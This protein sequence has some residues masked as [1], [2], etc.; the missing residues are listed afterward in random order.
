M[1]IVVVQHNQPTS[2]DSMIQS[3]NTFWTRDS[4]ITKSEILGILTTGREA[5]NSERRG[6]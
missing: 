4:V 1:F 3:N 2:S 5:S 6:R